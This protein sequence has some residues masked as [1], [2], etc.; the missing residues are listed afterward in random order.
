MPAKTLERI[1]KITRPHLACLLASLAS[2][3]AM[4]QTALNDTG[5]SGQQCYDVGSNLLGACATSTLGN[6]DGHTGRDA[7]QATNGKADGVLGFSFEKVC[8]NGQTAGEGVCPAKPKLGGGDNRWGC[9]RDRVTGLMWEVK[10]ASGL[11]AGNLN[12]TYYTPTFD[13]NGQLG[14][15]TDATGFINAVNAAGLCGASDWR[16][17]TA[18]EAQSLAYYGGMASPGGDGLIAIDTNWFPNTVEAFYWTS[19][20]FVLAGGVSQAWGAESA[21]GRTNNRIRSTPA[22]ARLVRTGP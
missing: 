2:L 16:L 7:T 4:A 1:M 18:R 9:T 3:S 10:T 13:P 20:P 5:I 15:A 14:A 21:T 8:N 12:Y 19:T 11:R 22:P 17:P 6:Q